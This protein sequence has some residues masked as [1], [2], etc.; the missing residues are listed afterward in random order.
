MF[1]SLGKV[2]SSRVAVATMNV[3]EK[4]HRRDL[5][6]LIARDTLLD[7]GCDCL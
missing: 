3:L 2:C 6:R 7:P 4:H 1:N 5:R